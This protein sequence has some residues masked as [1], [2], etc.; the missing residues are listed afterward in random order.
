M[1]SSLASAQP[2]LSGPG[3]EIQP[4]T[5]IGKHLLSASAL[6][7]V[8]LAPF[9]LSSLPLDL[10]FLVCILAGLGLGKVGSFNRERTEKSKMNHKILP[11]TE[12]APSHVIPMQTRGTEFNFQNTHKKTV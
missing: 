7:P 5:A 4:S 10:V 9:Q 3:N 12:K 8:G 1:T 6:L 2:V 11:K